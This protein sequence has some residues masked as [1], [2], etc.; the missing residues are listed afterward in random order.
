MLIRDLQAALA[1]LSDEQ[2][3]LVIMHDVEAYTLIELETILDTPLVILKPRLHRS[4][5]K[6][7]KL[8]SDDGTFSEQTACL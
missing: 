2:R 4:R 5:A 1:H 6:L 3:I 8:L 7:R